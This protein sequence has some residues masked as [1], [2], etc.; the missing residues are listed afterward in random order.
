MDL[1]YHPSLT[2][3][4]K[5]I[6][7]DAE[8]SKHLTKVLR[9]KRGDKLMITNGKGLRAPAAIIEI[10]SKKVTVDLE[11]ITEIAPLAYRL[12]IGIAPPKNISRFEWFLEKATEIGITEITPLLCD[13]SE[14]KNIKLERAEK[15]VLAAL[16]QSQQSHLPTVHP[17][18]S[19][20][21]FVV[22]H[23]QAWMAHCAEGKKTALF[24]LAKEQKNIT[25][26]IGPEGDFS[27]EEIKSIALAV[28]L[29][30]QRLRTE[31]AA[32]VA[33]QTIAL[34]Q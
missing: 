31:T 1:F 33:C 11:E 34:A 15:I 27:A 16:K 12:H 3:L 22:A 19:F 28:S 4:D 13:H 25:L 29:G 8:E 6:E 14:R 23:P 24:D 9:K 20:A 10:A 5:Q 2:L 30:E 21:D 17:M 18:T 7:L 26:L 32:I